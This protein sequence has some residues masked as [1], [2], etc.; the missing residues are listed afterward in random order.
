[1]NLNTSSATEV[2]TWS[3]TYAPPYALVVLSLGTAFRCT[4]IILIPCEVS[5]SVLLGYK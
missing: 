1:V 5:F 3:Y 4:R 2:N